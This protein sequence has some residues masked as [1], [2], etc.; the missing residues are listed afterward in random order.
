MIRYIGAGAALVALYI[1]FYVSKKGS[2]A[3]GMASVNKEA[4]AN[5]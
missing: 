5:K 2:L 3:S 4:E 1:A